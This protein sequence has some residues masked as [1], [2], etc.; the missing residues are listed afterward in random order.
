MAITA[1]SAALSE[2]FDSPSPAPA[3]PV[4][5]ASLPSPIAQPSAPRS[6]RTL[7][8]LF[9]PAASREATAPSLPVPET[10]AVPPPIAA[11]EPPRVSVKPRTFPAPTQARASY[12]T[13]YGLDE[14]PFGT[15]ADLRFL[16]HSTAHDRALQELATS[17]ARHDAVAVLT[18][19]H[20][21]GK[22]MLGRALVDQLDRRTLVSFV[23]EPPATPEALLG[24]LLVDFGVASQDD[25]AAGPLAS[26]SRVDLSGAL[27]DFLSS[28]AV[29]QA[30]ALLIVDDAHRLP[31]AVM[32]EVRAL[33]D[34]AASGKLLQLVLVGEPSLTR[35][36]KSSEFRDID[37]RV[38]LRAELGPLEEE[39]IAGYVAHRLAVAGRG[40]RVGFTEVALRKTF[41]L[42][43]GIP[44]V[45]NQ[46]CDR[47][48]TLGY[49]TSASAIDGDFVDEAA[50]QLGLMAAESAGSWRD[51]VMIVV[52]MLAL[53]LAGAAGAGWVFR[54]P[55]SRAL[56]QWHRG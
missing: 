39:E 43:R 6:P 53:M 52:L 13:F 40:E 2:A 21:M 9:P 26:A 41:S 3:A 19:P 14:K 35:Q 55:L 36:L 8:D 27:R 12:E 38:G 11:V 5:P 54:E 24:T 56:T 10:V 45:I 47:A 50:Q 37:D 18:G 51:R 4:V 28:L 46:I 42:S 33:A 48:L 15:A 31:T 22:T 29:L 34:M 20:G 49:Q 25:V 32:H 7:L 23:A 30:S 17:V 1:A 44:G 16:Y